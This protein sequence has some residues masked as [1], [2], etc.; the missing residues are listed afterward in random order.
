[1]NISEAMVC[2]HLYWP[3]IKK[4]VRKEGTNTYTYQH[5]KRSNVKYGKLSAKKPGEIPLYKLGVHLTGPYVIERKGH[6]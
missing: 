3:S 5:I 1:M 6:K 2:Q 4:A